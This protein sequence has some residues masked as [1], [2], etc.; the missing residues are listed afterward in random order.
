MLR[1]MIR[2]ED[3]AMKKN[4]MSV[5]I[6][7]LVFVNV[8]LTALLLITVL[9]QAKKANELVEKVA[10]AID[11]ELESGQVTNAST[12]PIS[13]IEVYAVN[14]GTAWLINLQSPD[15][16]PHHAQIA[17]SLSMNTQDDGYKD[18]SEALASKEALIMDVINRVIG[19]YMPDDLKNDPQGAQQEILKE[20]QTLFDDDFIV[21]V[22]FPTFTVE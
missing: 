3:V 18:G 11:L 13:D 9:P 5:L 21:G 20:L 6:L 17:V 4:L 2:K 19:G 15:D 14:G 22:T 10:S 16:K 1:F 12:I 8:A 7:A